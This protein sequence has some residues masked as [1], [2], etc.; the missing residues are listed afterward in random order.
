MIDWDNIIET[1]LGL[2]LGIA[3]CLM[4]CALNGCSAARPITAE[5]IVYKT[6]TLYKT[7]VRADTFRVLDSVFV[8]Q[9]TRGDTIYKEKTSYKWRDRVSLRV[10]TLHKTAIRT[11]SVRMPVPVER[12]LTAWEKTSMCVGKFTL[13]VAVLAIALLLLWLLHRKL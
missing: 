13:G 7:D 6:D 4:L 12:K 9:Y 3:V 10:D 11:D 5:R 1:V 8:F 2:L